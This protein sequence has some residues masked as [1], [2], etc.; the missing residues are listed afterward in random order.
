M[1][2][3]VRVHKRGNFFLSGDPSGQELRLIHYITYSRA[4]KHMFTECLAYKWMNEWA[5]KLASLRQ[6]TEMRYSSTVTRWHCGPPSLCHTRDTLSRSQ[7][8][9]RIGKVQSPWRVGKIHIY[10]Y[11]IFL[12]L[13]LEWNIKFSLKQPHEIEGI[14]SNIFLPFAYRIICK[15][16]KGRKP[17]SLGNSL[18]HGIFW[19][20]KRAGVI[21]IFGEKKSIWYC[22]LPML[23]AEPITVTLRFRN[24]QITPCLTITALLSGPGKCLAWR[25]LEL[26][27]KW[28]FQRLE[29][30]KTETSFLHHSGSSRKTT[31]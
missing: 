29:T 24:S 17:L 10:P 30:S 8:C 2:A 15:D 6:P 14:I 1:C 4:G 19:Q 16:V 28:L 18:V 21:A 12:V 31:W 26:V 22:P 20:W 3:C 25:L 9:L 11:H 13:F 23:E 27:L 7:D 5:D